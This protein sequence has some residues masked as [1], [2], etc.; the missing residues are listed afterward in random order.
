MFKE[1]ERRLRNEVRKSASKDRRKG[2]KAKGATRN[3]T[4]KKRDPIAWYKITRYVAVMTLF[5]GI[6][7]V[8][9]WV[10]KEERLP[11][12][13]VT[14][15]G[16]FKHASQ[17]LLEESV[18]P[19]VT[20][21]FMTINVSKLRAAG[22]GQAWIKSIQVQRHWPDRVH[23]VVEEQKAIAQWA[24]D[25]LVN[26]E[27]ELFFPSKS[28]FPKALV[29]L[30]GLNEE[31]RGITRRYV[32]IV[33]LFKP[34][35]L[36]VSQLKM[37][38]R[39]AWDIQFENGLKLLLGRADNEQRLARFNMIYKAGLHKYLNEIETIDMRYTNGVSVAWKLGQQPEF[40]GKV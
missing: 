35:G 18:K 31:S 28:S 15:E 27:G 25:G 20:G 9:A 34:L 3:P 37:D 39:Y 29:K 12:L 22:E 16:D 11:V 17:T 2:S 33:K 21:N 6:V 32:E 40:N 36:K 4:R 24:D 7:A 13:H 38:T 30:E 14:V 19:Y 1:K 5:V 23:L 10:Q 26:M 8:G